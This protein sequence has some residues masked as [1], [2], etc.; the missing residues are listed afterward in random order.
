MLAGYAPGGRQP[1]PGVSLLLLFWN[2]A[3]R[4]ESVRPRDIVHLTGK[5][6]L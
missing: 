3:W 6:A 4:C 5:Q 2:G 1:R